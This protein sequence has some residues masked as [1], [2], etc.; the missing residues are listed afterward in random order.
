MLT[1]YRAALP[2]TVILS[3]LIAFA[4]AICCLLAGQN[5]AT[6]Q[7]MQLF[8]LNTSRIGPH[9]Q[10]QMGLP[11]PDSS[12]NVTSVLLPRDI[13]DEIDNARDLPLDERDFFSDG[14]KAIKDPKG[15]IDGAKANITASVNDG[16]KALT[17]A[18]NQIKDKAKNAT[19]KIVSTFINETIATLGIQ[20]FYHAH[21]TTYCE[22]TYTN[23]G[24]EKNITYCSNGKPNYLHNSTM[25]ANTI[26]ENNPF[27]FINDLHLPDPISY[28]MKAVTLLSKFISSL[29]VLG[30]A[31]L[32]L[33]ILASGTSIVFL[34]ISPTGGPSMLPKANLAATI[35]AFLCL[36]VGT[37][38][39]DLLSK[40][41][42]GYFASNEG[43]GVQADA[44][45]NFIGVSIAAV[46]FTGIA[47]AVA[48]V[49]VVTGRAVSKVSGVGKR[50]GFKVAK[51]MWFGRKEGKK[52]SW[53]L[54]ERV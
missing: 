35:S 1:A 53:E 18:G 32:G 37:I 14:A 26:K 43:L 34:F 21:L 30:L 47:A 16:K 39:A 41:I 22:G 24:G 31:L 27:A 50:A 51:K 10:Q 46:V 2:A 36:L 9:L 33:S 48:A 11:P 6:L 12:F 4:L 13:L 49:D 8:T 19:A 28:A 5:P 52:E 38:L 25:G 40:K 45:K 7:N 54:N 44:G 20:D 42:V 15:T 29:Y 17:S 23:G 3:S